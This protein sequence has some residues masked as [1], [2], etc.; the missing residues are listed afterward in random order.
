MIPQH[1]NLLREVPQRLVY[2]TLTYRREDLPRNSERDP[3]TSRMSGMVDDRAAMEQ[4]ILHVLSTERRRVII[5]NGQP[6]RLGFDI[7][8]VWYGIE[9]EDYLI[10]SRGFGYFKTTIEQRLRDALL[11]D[12][13]IDD[14]IIHD[15]YKIDTTS[16]GVDF[17]VI[18]N[19][20]NISIRAEVAI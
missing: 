7:Y 20:G 10:L 1:D 18:T 15:I 14:I 9:L 19:V 13:R 12:D 16:A 3:Y 8:P 5:V 4:H 2:P 6:H 11:V 17:E